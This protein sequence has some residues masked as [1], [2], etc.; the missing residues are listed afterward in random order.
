MA[1]GRRSTRRCWNTFAA[2]IVMRCACSPGAR[3]MFS[4][5]TIFSRCMQGRHFPGY[6]VCSWRWARLFARATGRSNG[7][8]AHDRHS[9]TSRAR[10]DFF[11]RVCLS[12]CV[13]SSRHIEGDRGRQN[14]LCASP[15]YGASLGPPIESIDTKHGFYV[16]APQSLHSNKN[17]TQGAVMADAPLE[18]ASPVVDQFTDEAERAAAAASEVRW[19]PSYPIFGNE[20]LDRQ[21]AIEFECANLSASSSIGLE[22]RS[23]NA[24]LGRRRTRIY[25]LSGRSRRPRA[26]A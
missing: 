17:V 15:S 24:R 22:V 7:E 2:F 6:D 5:W 8:R 14:R 18:D 3:T 23:G 26:R 12:S 10:Y 1:T 13:Y 21:E 11:R 20:Y 4:F 25:R 19:R 9:E 16:M